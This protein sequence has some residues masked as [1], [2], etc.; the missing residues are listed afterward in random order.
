MENLEDS[1]DTVGV[2]AEESGTLDAASSGKGGTLFPPISL[3]CNKNFDVVVMN[4]SQFWCL[5]CT[6]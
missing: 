6:C 4:V 3:S 2:L 1:E 5:H